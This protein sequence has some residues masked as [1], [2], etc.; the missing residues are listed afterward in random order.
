M[1]NAIVKLVADKADRD[2]KEIDFDMQLGSDLGFDS[3]DIAEILTKLERD[4]DIKRLVP[5]DLTT[6]GHLI[7][8]A[9][10]IPIV[11]EFKEGQFHQN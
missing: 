10:K 1:R 11:C 7:A 4:Y 6:V 9:A 8:I 3:L 2:C 5:E